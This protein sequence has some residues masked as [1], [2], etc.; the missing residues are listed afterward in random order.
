MPGRDEPARHT[1][2]VRPVAHALARA[3]SRPPLDTASAKD[4]A[5]T[6]H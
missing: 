1:A 6:V 2:C 5:Q 3:V 4:F